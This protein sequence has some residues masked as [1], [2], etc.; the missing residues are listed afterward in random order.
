MHRASCSIE[1]VPCCFSMSSI[2]FQGHT[3]WKIDDLNPVWLKSSS[4]SQL[5]N[6]ASDLP[7][8]HTIKFEIIHVYPRLYI[9]A[10]I[11]FVTVSVLVYQE[12]VHITDPHPLSKWQHPVQ[13]VKIMSSFWR[14]VMSNWQLLDL[15]VGAAQS[16]HIL[17]IYR[18]VFWKC[19]ARPILLSTPHN[20]QSFH[21]CTG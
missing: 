11:I 21:V 15:C 5:S 4:R 7:C 19:D 13:P 20:R 9:Y 17:H 3:G 14:N 2:K 6:P 18:C 16:R 8:F 1:E 10:I 12:L